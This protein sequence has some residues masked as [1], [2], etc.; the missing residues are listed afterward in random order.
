MLANTYWS[1][2]GSVIGTTIGGHHVVV[3]KA[4][5]VCM[6]VDKKEPVCGIKIKLKKTNK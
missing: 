2:E 5:A 3:A 6:S 1:K 4:H